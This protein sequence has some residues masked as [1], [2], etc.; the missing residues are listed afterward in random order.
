ML[1]N[2]KKK[3]E[4]GH[5]KKVRKKTKEGK[6]KEL[7]LDLLEGDIKGAML[8]D[9]ILIKENTFE[10]SG[11]TSRS[12]GP[13]NSELLRGIKQQKS[14]NRDFY[15]EDNRILKEGSLKEKRKSSHTHRGVQ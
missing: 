14:R 15:W 4:K 1:W 10:N 3:T 8:I 6:E 13:F 2:L 9:K 7:T 11:S 12:K 5:G